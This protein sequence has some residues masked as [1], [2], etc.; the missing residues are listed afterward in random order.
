MLKTY[1]LLTHDG[2]HSRGTRE[3]ARKHKHGHPDVPAR[4]VFFITL[5]IK[6]WAVLQRDTLLC[7]EAEHS[8]AIN[9]IP[10][11][12]KWK[13]LLF[14]R[15]KMTS[16]GQPPHSRQ[17]E[18]GSGVMPTPSH[19]NADAEGGMLELVVLSPNRHRSKG[20]GCLP[21]SLHPGSTY[22]T[23]MPSHKCKT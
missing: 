14:M 6:G 7:T 22:E 16:E 11:L 5:W 9:D 23:T 10:G 8:P 15:G 2:L 18:P 20:T 13:Q 21:R 19:S 12:P 17:A 4:L 3:K 1:T